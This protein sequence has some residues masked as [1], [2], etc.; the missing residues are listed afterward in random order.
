MTNNKLKMDKCNQ[1]QSGIISIQR[2]I[3]FKTI[4]NIWRKQVPYYYNKKNH[5]NPQIKINFIL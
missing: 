4:L 1:K 5:G 3:H 2:G